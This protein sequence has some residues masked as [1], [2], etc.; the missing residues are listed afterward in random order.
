IPFA[1]SG[2]VFDDQHLHTPYAYQY[3]LSVQHEMA[4]NLTGEINYVGSSSKGLTGLI[5]I[6]PFVLGTTNRIQN[7]PA[8]AASPSMMS[9]CDAAFGP[10]AADQ[11]PF[12]IMDGFQNI[13]FASFNSLESSLTKHIS[14]NRF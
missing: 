2:G 14:E 5:D 4:K 9:F 8:L 11:C 7:V 13:G 12:P 6:N 10:S 1:P 3:N